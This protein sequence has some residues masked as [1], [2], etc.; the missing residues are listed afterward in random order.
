MEEQGQKSTV[1][2]LII[3]ANLAAAEDYNA[4]LQREPGTA[5]IGPWVMGWSRPGHIWARGM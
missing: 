3:T 1:A 4:L 2:H 5:G